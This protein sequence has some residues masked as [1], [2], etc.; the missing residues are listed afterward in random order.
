M[1]FGISALGFRL[2]NP[3]AYRPD[4]NGPDGISNIVYN[5]ITSAVYRKVYRVAHL[6][7]LDCDNSVDPMTELKLVYNNIAS[8]VCR[9]VY[10]VVHPNPPIAIRGGGPDGGIKGIIY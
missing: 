2:S 6:K 10:R 8:T 4:C 3:V 1:C 7:S 9:N 5:N